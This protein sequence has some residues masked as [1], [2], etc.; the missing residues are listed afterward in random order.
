[1]DKRLIHLRGVPG[2]LQPRRNRPP[3]GLDVLVDRVPL[4]TREDRLSGAALTRALE[5]VLVLRVLRIA[6]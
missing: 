4:R 5:V 1:M 3:G 6:A 2:R